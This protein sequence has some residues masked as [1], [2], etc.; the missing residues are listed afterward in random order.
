MPLEADLLAHLAKFDTAPFLFVGSG[1]SRRYIATDDWMGLLRRFADKTDY[2]FERYRADASRNPAV[3]ATSIAD[4]FNPIWWESDEYAPSR[5]AF[6]DPE[7]KQSPLKIEVARYVLSASA[8]RPTAGVLFDEL[9]LL[10][11]AVV[12]GVITTNYDVLLESVFPDFKV[13]S[14]QD[15]LLF[16]TTYGVGELFKIHGDAQF[17]ET[18]VLT[19]EDFERFNDRNKYLAAKLLTICVEHPV[20]FLGYSLADPNVREILLNI[21]AVL[22]PANLEK[23]RDRLIF[24]KWSET[25]A[26]DDV[27]STFH[28]I[29]GNQIPIISITVSDFTGVFSAIAKLKPRIPSG[30]LRRVKEQVYDLV[31][32]SESKGTLLVR[33]LEDDVD[34]SQVEIVIGVGVRQQLALEGLV[35]WNR[36]QVMLEVLDQSLTGNQKAM[37]TVAREVL[38][39]HLSGTT[40]CALF[41]Y[42]K[43]ANRLDAAGRLSD[44]SALHARVITRTTTAIALVREPMSL[45]RKYKDLAEACTSFEELCVDTD[46]SETLLVLQVID[47]NKVNL[48]HLRGYLRKHYSETPGGKPT[49][50]WAK[51]VCIYDARAFG[52]LG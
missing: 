43:G 27:V 41:Y 13:Y 46:P 24:V 33:D 8:N 42:L 21:S 2:P 11:K 49:T 10:S 9:S 5:I 44:A 47:L 48:E 25:G 15:A 29:D 12:E 17:P 22:T 51:A 34:P 19:A 6:P 35:G 31:S 39:Q 18:M 4:E 28:S 52:P 1:I 40:N 30:V 20:I 36:K 3:M 26:Q 14:G 32:T 23:L 38:P 50:L 7:S 16:N 45:P 37:D